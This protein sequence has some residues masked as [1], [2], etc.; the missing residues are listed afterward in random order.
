VVEIRVSSDQ[1]G[2]R[3]R[4]DVSVV[5]YNTFSSVY[6]PFLRD[7]SFFDGYGCHSGLTG[8]VGDADLQIL[9]QINR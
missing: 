4:L 3:T 2:K 9:S 8:D 5:L 7:L 6:T 1:I